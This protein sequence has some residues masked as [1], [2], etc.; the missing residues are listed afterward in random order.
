MK[1]RSSLYRLKKRNEKNYLAFRKKRL[2]IRNSF[3]KK[4]KSRQG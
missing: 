3:F 2:Y 4:Y 1:V